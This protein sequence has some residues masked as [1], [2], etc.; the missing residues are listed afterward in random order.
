MRV[1]GELADNCTS[2]IDAAE[3]RQYQIHDDYIR[4]QT[5]RGKNRLLTGPDGSDDF[6]AGVVA[7]EKDG[8]SVSHDAVIVYDQ[9]SD[10]GRCHCAIN[11]KILFHLDGRSMRV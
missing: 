3:D 6:H 1:R 9:N 10:D 11:G 2:G 8:Q 7:I 4:F 5:V